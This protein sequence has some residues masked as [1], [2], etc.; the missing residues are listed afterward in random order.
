MV[1]SRVTSAMLVDVSIRSLP[2][3]V[4][5]VIIVVLFLAATAGAVGQRRAI[6]SDASIEI[7]WHKFK[8]AVI[9]RDKVS[10]ARLS[11][12][13]IEMPYGVKAVRTQADLIKRYRVV[14][15]QETDAAKCFAK[16]HPEFERARPKEF[17]I[18]CGFADGGE[19]RPLLYIFTL[20]RNGWK[21][22]AFDNI[23]E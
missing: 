21:F 3:A 15:N 17:I 10:V 9:A 8:T 14:F 12:F 1:N 19:E 18:S 7:F 11:R 6:H 22:S 5:L 16:A 20:T 23:N 2:L 4:P 13:P